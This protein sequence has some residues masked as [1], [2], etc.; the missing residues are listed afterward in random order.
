V[1]T[2]A[3]WLYQVQQ[4][5]EYDYRLPSKTW[6]WSL[7]PAAALY[8]IEEL[9]NGHLKW[10]D[11]LMGIV[12]VLHLF[13]PIWFLRFRRVVDFHFVVPAEVADFWPASINEPLTVGIYLPL[14][15]YQPWDWQAVPF[16]VPF[17]FSMSTMYYSAQI[18]GSPYLDCLYASA[19]GVQLATKSRSWQ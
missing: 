19:L 8:A 4:V 15:R 13:K 14:L 12:L 9:R 10:H 11:W 16:M 1:A 7:S 3:D 17:S 18:L 2:P 6:I 5:E